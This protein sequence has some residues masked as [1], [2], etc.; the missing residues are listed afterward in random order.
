M[1]LYRRILRAAERFESAADRS[2]IRSEAGRLFRVNA[3]ERDP[4]EV[5]KKLFE[6]ESR[7]ELGVHYGIPYPRPF[8]VIPGATGQ[9]REAVRPAY[10]H[11]DESVGREMVGGG[12][13]SQRLPVFRE[14]Q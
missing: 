6:G 9:T 11:S 8:N 3:G 4:E 14:D 13:A 5:E 2:Y 7:L 1:G 12:V 10:L